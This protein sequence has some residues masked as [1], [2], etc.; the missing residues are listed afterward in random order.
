[1]PT[2][3]KQ[4]PKQP[5]TR[6]RRSRQLYSA[7]SKGT[8]VSQKS[9]IKFWENWSP[10]RRAV[11]GRTLKLMFYYV[12]GYVLAVGAFFVV[13]LLTQ[14]AVDPFIVQIT[15]FIVASI[16]GGIHKSIRWQEVG[17]DP[18]ALPTPSADA[19]L[20]QIA[21]PDTYALKKEGTE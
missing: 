1:M 8:R 4:S 13:Y 10:K 19:S 17:I 5:L 9:R 16:T 3:K 20:P 15:G 12:L 6:S 18:S 21:L 14:Q 7:S 2:R 11:I